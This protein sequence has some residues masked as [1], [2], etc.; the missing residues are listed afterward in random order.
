MGSI[1]QKPR[2]SLTEVQG[3]RID[4]AQTKGI[5]NKIT[6]EGVPVNPDRWIYFGRPKTEARERESARQAGT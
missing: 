1:F 6:T 3:R 5:F 4:L 2:V